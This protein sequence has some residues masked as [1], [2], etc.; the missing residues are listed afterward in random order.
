MGLG[1]GKNN[2]AKLITTKHLIQFA[3]EKDCRN[4]QMFGDSKIVCNWIIKQQHVMLIL[5]GTYWMRSIYTFQFLAI[6]YVIIYTGNETHLLTNFPKR[7][8]CSH[9][10]LGWYKNKWMGITTNII[11]A[12]LWT[13]LHK[14]NRSPILYDVLLYLLF[15]YFMLIYFQ[16]HVQKISLCAE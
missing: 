9:A 10:T 5:W 12:L 15:T 11:I 1:G 2:Y 7:Q 16:R 14:H 8:Q 13:M 4:L 3:I 6:L